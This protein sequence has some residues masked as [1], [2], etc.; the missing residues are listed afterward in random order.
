MH[1]CIER[2]KSYGIINVKS[3]VDII[4]EISGF[5]LFVRVFRELLN[6]IVHFSLGIYIGDNLCRHCIHGSVEL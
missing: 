3:L 4:I 1:S 5:E 6:E 2:I